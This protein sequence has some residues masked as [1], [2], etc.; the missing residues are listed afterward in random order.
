M[1][2]IQIQWLIVIQCP[3]NVSRLIQYAPGGVVVLTNYAWPYLAI[4]PASGGQRPSTKPAGSSVSFERLSVRLLAVDI[5]AF[6]SHVCTSTAPLCPLSLPYSKKTWAALQ[7]RMYSNSYSVCAYQ[8]VSISFWSQACLTHQISLE[9]SSPAV[10][11]CLS[12]SFLILS[13]D[14]SIHICSHSVQWWESH[15]H[16]CRVKLLGCLSLDFLVANP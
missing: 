4:N 14:I 2:A 10:E 16:L 11:G 3:K 6:A 8:L 1:A 15:N 7:L 12:C 9:M 5:L 13:L